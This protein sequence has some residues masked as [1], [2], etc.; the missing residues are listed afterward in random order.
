M[1]VKSPAIAVDISVYMYIYLAKIWLY[2]YIHT[3]IHTYYKLDCAFA[4]YIHTYI[5]YI[6]T[7]MN[8]FAFARLMPPI[9]C[10][11]CSCCTCRQCCYLPAYAGLGCGDSFVAQIAGWWLS[12]FVYVVA[13]AVVAVC[14]ASGPR[15]C[16]SNPSF[17]LL[18]LFLS[19]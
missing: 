19:L 7:D 14:N 4:P 12:M 15:F 3:Y 18:L 6:L 5:I 10:R 2:A 11:C 9:G 13:N 8:A 16:W 17:L 1:S